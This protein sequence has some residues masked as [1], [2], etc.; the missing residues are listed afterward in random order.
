MNRF[1]PGGRNPGSFGSNFAGIRFGP[2]LPL[3]P[4][5]K[6]LLLANTAVFLLMMMP[7]V[8]RASLQMELGL[9]HDA[10]FAQGKIWQLA[11]YMFLHGGFVHILFNMLMLWMFGTTIE[12]Q[13]GGRDFLVYY[14]VCGVG[15][16]L[17]DWIMSPTSG[18]VTI[19]ASGAIFGIFMAYALMYPDREVLLWFVIRVRM[20][21]L[22][23][24][25]IGMGVLF[26]LTNRQDGVAH[27]AHL[28][29]A[30][31]GW[32]YLKADWRMGALGKKLRGERAR[33]VMKANA[34]REQHRQ[35]S[36]QDID[37]ILDKI[38]EKGI[39]SLTEAERRLLDDASK[40]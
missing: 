37:A 26:A 1:R 17:A 28:G 40:Q 10:V 24:I 34:Q 6:G 21:I 20:K 31:F 23:W 4:G 12:H 25:M 32:L 16:G 7:G 35:A 18:A 27:Y 3:S 22:M 11:T 36:R 5:V 15:G 8:D 14:A 9:V 39:D 33:R 29:G 13:W 38:N 19:G 30:L 2:G